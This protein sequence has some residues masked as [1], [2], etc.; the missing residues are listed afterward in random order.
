MVNN[1][2]STTTTLFEDSDYDSDSDNSEYYDLFD[3]IY[4][5]EEPS[6]TKFN[7]VYCEIYS[8][9]IHGFTN[10]NYETNSPHY[11]VISRLKNIPD[12]KKTINMDYFS[13]LNSSMFHLLY[14]RHHSNLFNHPII[15]NFSNIVNGKNYL[16]PEIALCMLSDD[17]ESICIIK[18]IWLRLIQRTWKKIYQQRKDILHKRSLPQSLLYREKTG[19]WPKDCYHIPSLTGMLSELS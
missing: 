7:L 15:R 16:K 19:R 4:D 1:I 9:R 2:I 12:L 13:Y 8:F 11:L 3:N 10:K 6:L 17:N 5:P 14:A 18:T